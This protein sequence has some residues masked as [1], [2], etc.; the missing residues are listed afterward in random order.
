MERTTRGS[1]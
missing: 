1:Q